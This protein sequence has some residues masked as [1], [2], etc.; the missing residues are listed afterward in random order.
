[1]GNLDR[2]SNVWESLAVEGRDGWLFD[3]RA[4][5]L[6]MGKGARDLAQGSEADLQS[7]A[8]EWFATLRS[9]AQ[10]LSGRGIQYLHI[11][12]PEK[13]GMAQEYHDAPI[14]VTSN[15]PLRFL[16]TRY[17]SQLPF[18]LDPSAYMLR[19]KDEYPLYWKTDDRWTP[20]A[21]YMTCQLL[22]GRLGVE[23]NRQLL[24]Y[25]HS[26]VAP[27]VGPDSATGSASLQ[28]VRHYRFQ[29]RSKRRYANKLTLR[30]EEVFH[31]SEL[32]SSL[33][34]YGQGA[35]SVFENRHPHAQASPM[36]VM[37]FGD[38]NS[39]DGRTLLTGM[40]A[41]TF[42]EVH[43]VWA[44]EMDRDYI[45]Q[46]KPDVVITQ[47][48][49]LQMASP[50]VQGFDFKAA[51]EASLRRLEQ[52]LETRQLTGD[53]LAGQQDLTGETTDS[54]PLATRVILAAEDYA[55]EPP[56]LVQAHG[57]FSDAETRMHA[58]EVS[59]TEVSGAKVYFTGPDW[60]VHD[61][62]GREVLK[63]NSSRKPLARERWWGRRRRL[64][65]VSLLF[66][67]SAGA[68][69]YYHWM[70]EILPK[71]GMLEREGIA[72]DSID[73]F[74]V[75][76][77]S[78]D[79]QRQT[80]ARFGI[81][82]SRIVETENQPH[83]HCE[84][85]LHVGINFGINLKMHRFVPLWMKHLYPADN[86]GLPRLKLYISRPEGVRRGIS[87]EAEIIPL[88]QDAGFTVMAMEGLSVPEQAALMARV[89]V[90]M[91]PH[92]GA[93]TNM[94]FCRPGITVI[95]LFSRHV[96]PYYYGL[97]A[98]C[99]HRY[100]AILENPEEDYPRLVNRRIAQENAVRH[101]ETARLN[102]DVPVD[103]VREL[104]LSL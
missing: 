95:E 78:A 24:A 82:A 97:A 60:L 45:D 49:E 53:S 31:P 30:R 59:L 51:A 56:G 28:A 100:H 21:C 103:A 41:E 35:Q 71:L 52:D 88:L 23:I 76:R 36:T 11:G 38:A 3:Q 102:F 96:Y 75:R 16:K 99:G 65:G 47:A 34:C 20:W 17:E 46:V 37:L 73:H 63:R 62:Q 98:S 13:L 22:C 4:V 54:A 68:H 91:S 12:V 39:G 69:C 74:L 2:Q 9:N 42:S 94:V 19:K 104:L 10:W 72:V 5:K 29:R 8:A 64:A 57:D 32:A 90:L 55:L 25:P 1:M 61:E 77:I 86:S 50:P 83:L 48:S 26:E 44:P 70:L 93:L 6:L 27:A 67:N 81:D 18:L 87:N 14:D 80:L 66:G 101:R 33:D 15:S 40:L 84:K 92:G 85:F 43:F 89:D 58:H 79:W 7:V